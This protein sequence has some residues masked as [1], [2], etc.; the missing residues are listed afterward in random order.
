MLWFDV[1]VHPQRVAV[2]EVASELKKYDVSVNVGGE[3]WRY[4]IYNKTNDKRN[5]TWRDRGMQQAYYHAKNGGDHVT[6]EQVT[7]SQY[8]ARRK[9][10]DKQVELF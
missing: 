4:R 1:I 6:F 7:R 8:V 9:V 5:K 3:I 2:I 10:H